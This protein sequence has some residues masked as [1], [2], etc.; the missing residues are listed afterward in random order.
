MSKTREESAVDVIYKIMDA[1]DGL[2]KKISI[3][4]SNLKLLSNKVSKISKAKAQRP[5]AIDIDRDF[6]ENVIT[7]GVQPDDSGPKLILG[8]VSVFGHVIDGNKVPMEDVFVTIHTSDSKLIKDLATNKD[9][10]WSVRLPPGKYIVKY[11][12]KGYKPIKRTI[13]LSKNMKKYEV[14]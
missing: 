9:G 3:I 7:D 8:N 10:Y 13:E 14:K 11:E 5:L 4:D 12:M 1:L 2:D 6:Q